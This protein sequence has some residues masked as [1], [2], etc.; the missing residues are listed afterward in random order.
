MK[1]WDDAHDEMRAAMAR[2]V[3]ELQRL[4]G[5]LFDIADGM[6]VCEFNAVLKERQPRSKRSV[7]IVEQKNIIMA[8]TPK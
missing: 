4:S 7:R 5:D 2:A 6:I 3:N 8:L 1:D